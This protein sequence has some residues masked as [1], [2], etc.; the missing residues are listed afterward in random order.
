MKGFIV[1]VDITM[2]KYFS[3]SAENEEQAR[4]KVGKII[5][6]NPY[7]YASNFSHYVGHEIVDA[8]EDKEV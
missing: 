4:A 1:Q 5:A 8:E 3:V 2:S 6:E 7:N